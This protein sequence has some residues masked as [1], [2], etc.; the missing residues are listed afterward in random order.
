MNTCD[1]DLGRG[2]TRGRNKKSNQFWLR[3]RFD[4]IKSAAKWLRL[5]PPSNQ[6][7]SHLAPRALPPIQTPLGG[8]S[9]FC[10]ILIK[11]AAKWLR[12]ATKKSPGGT[13]AHPLRTAT[14]PYCNESPAEVATR[15]VSQEEEKNK[16]K[17]R[18]HVISDFVFHFSRVTGLCLP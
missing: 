16:K 13:R 17:N 6:T 10:L 5:P 3:N 4:P 14:L 2:R 11:R 7:R 8:R 12:A 15:I 18:R 1:L 9:H